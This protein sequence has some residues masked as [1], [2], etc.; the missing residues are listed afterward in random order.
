MKYNSL[1]FPGVNCF[2]SANSKRQQESESVFYW[3]KLHKQELWTLCSNDQQ[4]SSICWW[5]KLK[6]WR[7]LE[8]RSSSSFHLYN[9]LYIYP[10]ELIMCGRKR[11]TLHGQVC[12]SG[13][14]ADTCVQACCPCSWWTLLPY[15]QQVHR[16]DSYLSGVT[17]PWNRY[18]CH[19]RPTHFL[20][21][22]QPQLQR[23][24]NSSPILDWHASSKVKTADS[25]TLYFHH[26]GLT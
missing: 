5:E 6:V 14:K 18:S 4:L 17:F 13:L 12:F 3:I 24:R 11:H 26:S 10:S 16:S 1:Y 23:F 22:F 2:M 7:W 25:W 8:T 20:A 21:T 19:K 9:C 15:L